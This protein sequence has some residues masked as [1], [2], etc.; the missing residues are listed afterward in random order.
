MK[1]FKRQVNRVHPVHVSFA[2][3]ITRE[4]NTFYDKKGVMKYCLNKGI[5]TEMYLKMF[6]IDPWAPLLYL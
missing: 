6:G 2:F 4:K 5:Y 3:V 1:T